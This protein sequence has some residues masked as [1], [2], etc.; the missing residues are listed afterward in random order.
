MAAV[1]AVRPATPYR[2]TPYSVADH[3]RAAADGDVLVTITSIQG[4]RAAQEPSGGGGPLVAEHFG[5]GQAG[6]VIDGDVHVV[7][8]DRLAALAVAVGEGRC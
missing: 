8:A 3:V 5:V 4:D 2:F 1:L 7:P 6:R